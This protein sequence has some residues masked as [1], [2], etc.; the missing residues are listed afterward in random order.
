M[1]KVKVKVKEM[2]RKKKTVLKKDQMRRQSPK[3]LIKQAIQ[4]H[5]NLQK[6]LRKKNLKSKKMTRKRTKR[7]SPIKKNQ[8]TISQSLLTPKVPY[9]NPSQVQTQKKKEMTQTLFLKSKHKNQFD[10]TREN[11]LRKRNKF[12]NQR[13]LSFFKL[14]HLS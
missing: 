14:R 7:K 13:I 9:P 8:K 3:P 4:K 6:L 10:L 5:Q 12:L 2:T 11:K 1:K